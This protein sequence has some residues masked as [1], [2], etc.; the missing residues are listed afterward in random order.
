M[1]SANKQNYLI[2]GALSSTLKNVG[3][4]QEYDLIKLEKP[5]IFDDYINNEL[6]RIQHL[7]AENENGNLFEVKKKILAIIFRIKSMIKML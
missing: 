6:T 4:F 1:L 7:I 2:D 5:V 3:I